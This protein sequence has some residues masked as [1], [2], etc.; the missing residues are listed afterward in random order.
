MKTKK[1]FKKI[2]IKKTRRKI[3]EKKIND[4]FENNKKS[5]NKCKKTI[6]KN[7]K[8][9][10]NT[11]KKRKIKRKNLTKKSN[12]ERNLVNSYLKY[13]NSYNILKK[14]LNNDKQNNNY[15]FSNEYLCRWCGSNIHNTNKCSLN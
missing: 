14:K 3:C 11:Y 1:K 7:K 8:Q 10:Q 6:K 5:L 13:Y 12:M 2:L 15:N 4:C 9:C